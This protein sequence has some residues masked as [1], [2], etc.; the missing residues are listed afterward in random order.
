MKTGAFDQSFMTGDEY[1]TWLTE[2]AATHRQLMDKAG[3]LS[4]K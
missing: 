4:A 1:K 2:A 3:F